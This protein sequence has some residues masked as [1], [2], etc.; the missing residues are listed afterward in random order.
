[1]IDF[2]ILTKG[3]AAFW[4]KALQQIAANKEGWRTVKRPSNTPGVQ[5]G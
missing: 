2:R 4:G 3:G 1:M 5:A